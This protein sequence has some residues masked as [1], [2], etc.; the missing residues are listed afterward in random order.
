MACFI[1]AL[2]LCIIPIGILQWLLMTY[3]LINSSFF[4]ILSLKKHIEGL[5]AKFFAVIGMIV[6]LQ[7][8]FFLVTKFFFINVDPSAE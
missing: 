5:Q 1:P 7:L 6:V 3:A 4:L 8:V 2:L